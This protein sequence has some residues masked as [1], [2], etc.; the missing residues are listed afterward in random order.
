VSEKLPA[1]TGER[2]VSILLKNGF[3]VARQS[4][5]HVILKHANGRRT[6]VPMHKGRDLGKGLLH[7]IMGDAGL[8]LDDLKR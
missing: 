7:Q 3:Y 4:G 1:M 8:T 2:L 5:S 6:T